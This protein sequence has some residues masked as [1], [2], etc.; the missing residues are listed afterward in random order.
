MRIAWKPCMICLTIPLAA[1]G[2]SALLAGDSLRQFQLLRRPPLSPPGWVFPVVWTVL[3]LLMGFASYLIWEKRT[4]NRAALTGYGLQLLANVL[5]PLFFFRL[6]WYLAAFFW[7]ILL[8][9]LILA[10]MTLFSR[11]SAWAAGLLL[12]YLLWV[13]FAGY[14]NLGIYLL[15]GPA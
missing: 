14:L 4:G 6:S 10:V 1:G 8:W 11:L 7:L 2:I 5:W 15:N 3:Y 12:P 9:L 13:S